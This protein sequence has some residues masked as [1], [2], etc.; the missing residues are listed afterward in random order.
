MF[1]DSKLY[2]RFTERPQD[3][4]NEI[5]RGKKGK[6]SHYLVA[7]TEKTLVRICL[8]NGVDV[9]IIWEKWD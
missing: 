9:N 5:G 7:A 8:R 3:K 6:G 4:R 2:I 1:G